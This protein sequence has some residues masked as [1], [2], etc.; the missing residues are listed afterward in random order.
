MSCEHEHT[1]GDDTVYELSKLFD[2]LHKDAKELIHSKRIRVKHSEDGR[3]GRATCIELGQVL[4]RS[5]CTLA[6]STHDRAKNEMTANSPILIA[7]SS[8]LY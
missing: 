6:S 1:S 7:Y 3:I 4:I 2:T 5:L 8:P